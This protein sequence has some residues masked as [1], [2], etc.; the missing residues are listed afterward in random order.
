MQLAELREFIEH[1][2]AASIISKLVTL[3]LPALLNIATTPGSGA[4][5]SSSMPL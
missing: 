1:K 2:Q 3:T 4:E 5:L